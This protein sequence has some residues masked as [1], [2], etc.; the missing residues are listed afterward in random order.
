MAT[1]DI[2]RPSASTIGIDI[3]GQLL[4]LTDHAQAHAVAVDFVD[5]AVE[6]KASCQS[7]RSRRG[8]FPVLR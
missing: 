4:A 6:I 7:H 1:L 3:A 5:L 2:V 8:P